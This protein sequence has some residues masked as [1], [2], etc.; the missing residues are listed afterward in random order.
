MLKTLKS[1]PVIITAVI[2]LLIAS[3]IL[4]YY[5]LFAGE[6]EEALAEIIADIIDNTDEDVEEGEK[7]IPL[8]PYTG[9]PVE[10]KLLERPFGIMIDNSPN[11]RP[12][13]GLQDASY[14]YEIIAEGGVTRFLALFHHKFDGNYG[15]IRSIRP[16]YA[17]LA[18]ENDAVM[19]HCGSSP[20]SKDIL[21][22]S[23]YANLDEIPYTSY[24]FREQ[25]RRSPHNLFTDFDR[26]VRGAERL[27]LYRPINR[28]PLFEFAQPPDNTGLISE[29]RVPFSSHNQVRYVWDDSR[30][31]YLRYINSLPHHDALN[32]TQVSV[33]NI[34][35]QYA[36]LSFISEVHRDYRIVGSGEGLFICDGYVEKIK[37]SKEGLDKE[38]AF[39][40]DDG[41]PVKILPGNTWVHILSPASKAVLVE[42][43]LPE[44]GQKTQ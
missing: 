39:F 15:P 34:I 11:A 44:N 5:F 1:K 41:I 12:Q 4:V 9:L 16:Y 22:R 32:D 42:T 20:Q 14:V 33:R 35:V 18:R 36:G 21:R 10:E 25:S 40:Y 19:A 31:S 38:T 17:H 29:V 30:N 7:V 6:P 8:S 13:N 24:F 28:E 3:G 2:T 37:W 26:L 43:P 23:E 27:N